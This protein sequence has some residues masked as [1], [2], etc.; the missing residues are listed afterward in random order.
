MRERD[1]DK[2]YF[3]LPI[4]DE[5]LRELFE[6]VYEEKEVFS[7]TDSIPLFSIHPNHHLDEAVELDPHFD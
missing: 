2:K 4:S 6:G 7:P 5:R 3:P 1:N